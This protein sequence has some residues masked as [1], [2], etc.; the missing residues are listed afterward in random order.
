MKKKEFEELKV[1]DKVALR[2]I[3][4]WKTGEVKELLFDKKGK[5]IGV[6]IL[7]EGYTFF[8]HKND[9]PSLYH[10][11]EENFW[12]EADIHSRELI[13]KK[14][15]DLFLQSFENWRETEMRNCLN[16][17]LLADLLKDGELTV[18]FGVQVE[19]KR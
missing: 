16:V 8:S 3:F 19:D 14:A 18:T 12:N 4:G 6:S 15:E 5:L 10:N 17:R 1:G 2:E 11:D 7:A 9:C 13:V